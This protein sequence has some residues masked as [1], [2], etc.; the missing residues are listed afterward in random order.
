MRRALA[1]G[2][3]LVLLQGC[4]GAGNSE[5]PASATHASGPKITLNVKGGRSQMLEAC[6]SS[7]HYNVYSSGSP[8]EFA[9]TVSPVPAGRWK[10][11][12]KLKICRGSAFHDV[13]KV[14]A[15][16]DKGTGG[17][18]GTLPALP[19][20]TYFARAGLYEDGRSVAR[21]DKGNFAVR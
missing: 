8:I 20:G 21:S 6:G 4:G 1:A 9:G 16:G 19:R 7:N 11:K 10:V 2:L 17:F 3:A 15:V 5:A 13:Q 18:R 12:V 14:E